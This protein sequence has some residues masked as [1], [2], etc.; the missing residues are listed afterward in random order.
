MSASRLEQTPALAMNLFN[1]ISPDDFSED[2]LCDFFLTAAAEEL[3]RPRIELDHALQAFLSS[4][5][6]PGNIRELKNLIYRLSC[7]ADGVAGLQHLPM[8]PGVQKVHAGSLFQ[9]A[10]FPFLFTI[11][12]HVGFVVAMLWWLVLPLAWR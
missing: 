1:R 12:V 6:Y 5:R 10:T 8:D 3:E 2:S 4:Y 11:L 7:L 9:Y